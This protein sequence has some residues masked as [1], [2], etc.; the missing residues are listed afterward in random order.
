MSETIVARVWPRRSRAARLT[1]QGERQRL[2]RQLEGLI[3]AARDRSQPHG[4]QVPVNRAEVIACSELIH[5]LADDLR[6]DAPLQPPGIAMLRRLLRD[7]GSPL[8]GPAEYPL[9]STLVHAR[10]ALLLH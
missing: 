2:A 7:G 6:G 8:Y 4:A 9:E 5:E 1:S 3:S 10:D